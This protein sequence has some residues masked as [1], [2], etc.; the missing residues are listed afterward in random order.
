MNSKR[1]PSDES[2]DPA[3]LSREDLMSELEALRREVRSKD[4]DVAKAEIK[5]KL[6]AMGRA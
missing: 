3:M 4:G 5:K 6:K 1:I 2:A